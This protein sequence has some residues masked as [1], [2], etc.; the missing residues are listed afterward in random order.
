LRT[1]A[2]GKPATYI[3]DMDERLS[4]RLQDSCM[5]KHIFYKTPYMLRIVAKLLT[6]V[7]LP[8]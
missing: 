3:I 5:S 1:T 7:R 4:L 8:D 6:S 2:M